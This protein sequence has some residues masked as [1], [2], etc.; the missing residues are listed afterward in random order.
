MLKFNLQLTPAYS[1]FGVAALGSRLR[2]IFV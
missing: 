2:A 1:V